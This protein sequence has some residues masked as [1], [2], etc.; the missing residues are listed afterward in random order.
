MR[1]YTSGMCVARLTQTNAAGY[2]CIMLRCLELF[3]I[4]L[5]YVMLPGI[6]SFIHSRTHSAVRSG[7]LVPVRPRPGAV[8]ARRPHPLAAMARGRVGARSRSTSR[9]FVSEIPHR[10]TTKVPVG[11]GCCFGAVWWVG[12]HPTSAWRRRG[13]SPPPP[14]GDGAGSRGSKVPVN[15]VGFG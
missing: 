5:W 6:P 10:W 7:E 13:S 12:S 2:V 15:V 8:V 14:C 9:G 11:T 1:I 4:I 3:G